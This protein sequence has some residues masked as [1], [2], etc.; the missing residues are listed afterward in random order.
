MMHVDL[1]AIVRWWTERPDANVCVAIGE[2]S[3]GEWN[4]A[5]RPQIGPADRAPQ[6]PAPL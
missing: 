6:A 5:L 3:Q 4:Y 1:N 2:A